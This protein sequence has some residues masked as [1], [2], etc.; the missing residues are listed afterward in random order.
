MKRQKLY[1]AVGKR[2]P[3]VL[4]STARRQMKRHKHLMLLTC[5]SPSVPIFPAKLPSH[6]ISR[7]RFSPVGRGVMRRSKVNPDHSGR[8]DRR[9]VSLRLSLR[10]FAPECQQHSDIT[11]AQFQQNSPQHSL[12]IT[13][14]LRCSDGTLSSN[15]YNQGGGINGGYI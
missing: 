12:P 10:T 6:P 5:K 2:V 1:I 13:P 9:R 15:L 3:P 11:A 7:M 8:G 4:I 14:L